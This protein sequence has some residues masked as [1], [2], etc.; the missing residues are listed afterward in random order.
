[1][2]VLE[3]LSKIQVEFKAPKDKY[4]SF[5]KYNYRSAESIL[6]S[7]K[8]LLMKHNAVIVVDEGLEEIN[9]QPVIRSKATL[10]ECENGESVEAVAYA[11]I[12]K[13]GGMALPQA[14]GSASS[15]AKKYALGNLLLIDDSQDAD[16]TNIH[17]KK[18]S[19][20]K[21]LELNVGD[22]NWDK[23]LGY[24]A[25]NKD[26]GLTAIVKMLETKYNVKATVKKEIEK[27]L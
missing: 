26:K 25:S 22:E 14:Y 27:S 2:S 19:E 5:G 1:M 24:V 16:S 23:V 21:K 6:E 17:S 9:G 11:G 8:P 3:K 15:Y 13:A 4:N 10:F 18:P 12:E 20:P 7:I